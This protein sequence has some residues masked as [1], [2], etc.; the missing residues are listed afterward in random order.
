MV[1]VDRPASV[2]L[3]VRRRTHCLATVIGESGFEA[4]AGPII[5][6]GYSGICCEIKFTGR[7]RGFDSVLFNL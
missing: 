6:S 1:I 4:R 2:V 5:A 7:H 3:L